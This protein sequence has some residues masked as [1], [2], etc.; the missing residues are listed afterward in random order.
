MGNSPLV[1]LVRLSP[2]CTPMEGKV[3]EA[4]VLHHS[5]K[6]T[7]AAGLGSTAQSR[8]GA[9]NYGIGIDE[10]VILTV[11][12]G[13]VSQASSD[14]S[15]DRRAITIELAN[16]AEGGEWPVSDGVLEKAVQ[17]GVDACQR[18]SETLPYLNYTGDFDGNLYMHAWCGEDSNYTGCPGQYLADRFC[19]YANE[20]NRRL[21]VE[22][23]CPDKVS[24][25]DRGD[26]VQL[27]PGAKYY[28]NHRIDDWVFGKML[29]V[30]ACYGKYYDVSVLPEGK[31][32][33][34]GRVHETYLMALGEE[35]PD[36][37]PEA[38]EPDPPAV[39]PDVPAVEA[40]KLP[41]QVTV[42][43]VEERSG[44]GRLEKGGWIEL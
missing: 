39:V 15:V 13:D 33:I 32:G 40:P 26:L 37:E 43:I 17:L 31:G 4:L 34:T 30:R 29:Y 6:K 23:R 44:F 18:H 27:L 12:E 8:K 35:A 9:A 5:A 21:G 10:K 16:S 42:T 24:R 19:W 25:F 36:R 41:R 7:T 38:V 14:Q 1:D 3:V 28:N 20:V 22:F 11:D 2:F